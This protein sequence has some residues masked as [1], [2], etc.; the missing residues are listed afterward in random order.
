MLS[1][2]TMDSSVGWNNHSG[3][4]SD[5]IMMSD[6]LMDLVKDTDLA[7]SLNPT[8]ILPQG[9]FDGIYY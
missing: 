3:I 8:D 7:K 2:D 1:G 6:N 5:D 9:E 4:E